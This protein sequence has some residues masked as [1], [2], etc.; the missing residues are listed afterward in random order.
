MYNEFGLE[1][2]VYFEEFLPLL[3]A[4]L[5]QESGLECPSKGDLR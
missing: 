1:F 3:G 5:L 4:E 2:L